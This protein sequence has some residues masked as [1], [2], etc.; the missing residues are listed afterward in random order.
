MKKESTTKNETTQLEK[1]L[2]D[3]N[4]KNEQLAKKL[5][6]SKVMINFLKKELKK[7]NG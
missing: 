2:R 1:A 7:N 6:E 5:E 3:A 4:K